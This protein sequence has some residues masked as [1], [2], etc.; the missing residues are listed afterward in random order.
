MSLATSSSASG[1]PPAP[2]ST[3]PALPK[4]PADIARAWRE[5][6]PPADLLAGRVVLVTGAGDGMG[7]A[8]ALACASHGARVVLL[9]RTV[10]KLEATYDAIEVL[11]TAPAAIYPM[12][13]EGAGLEDYQTLAQTLGQNYGRLDGLVHLAADGGEPMP[14]RYHDP[15]LWI[16]ALHTNLSAAF[17]LTQACLELLIDSKDSAV[18]FTTDA[19]ESPLQVYRGAYG[20]A[21]HAL[22]AL[23]LTWANEL[24]NCPGP[25]I[26]VLQPGPTR[27]RLRLGRYPAADPSALPAPEHWMP[28][29]LYALG[30]D[31]RALRGVYWDLT[32]PE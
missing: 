19:A 32:R 25:R 4:P 24:E 10:R 31:G 7:R 13:L 16:R 2:A 17:M 27:T 30:P 15:A 21:K 12:N 3:P 9:G 14:L 8:C 22:R 5:Y 1:Q 18:V 28:A 29:Y 20:I 23:A 6:H 26:N 11:R